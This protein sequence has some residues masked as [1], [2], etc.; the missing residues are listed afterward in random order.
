MTNRQIS[1]FVTT[2]VANF[3]SNVAFSF[4]IVSVDGG[5]DAFL[6]TEA[7]MYTVSLFMIPSDMS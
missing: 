2:E 7:H 5:L 6:P 1:V 3:L 4:F